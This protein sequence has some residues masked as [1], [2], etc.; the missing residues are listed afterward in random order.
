ML[1]YTYTPPD[2]AVNTGILGRDV[3]N[4]T[5]ACLVAA[6]RVVRYLKAIKHFKLTFNKAG[7]DLIDYSDADWAGDTITRKSTSGYVFFFASGDV[8]WTSRK[9]F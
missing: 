5:E 8:S 3:S 6:K 4:P 7:S 9:P 2:I 1:F